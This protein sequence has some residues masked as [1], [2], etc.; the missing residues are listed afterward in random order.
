MAKTEYPGSEWWV[1]LIRTSSNAL[2]CGVTNDVE[3]RF[4]MHQNGKGAKA[5][6]GKGPLEL[7]W[8]QPADS[9]SGALKLEAAM[10]KLPKKRKEKIVLERQ[11]FELNQS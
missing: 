4:R 5:L 8:K 3:R 10:K 9:K 6:R 7:V 2:Y 11:I 1:Y